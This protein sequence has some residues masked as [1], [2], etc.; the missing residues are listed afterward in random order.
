MNNNRYL[1]P[2][3]NSIKVIEKLYP[4]EPSPKKIGKIIE[5]IKLITSN[6]IYGVIGSAIET[7][8]KVCSTF[9]S[10]KQ[11]AKAVKYVVDAYE[12]KLHAEVELARLYKEKK[13]TKALTLFIE[14]SFQERMDC[15]NKE[16]LLRSREIDN[17]HSEK[18]QQI[19]S[20]HERAILKMNL[21][22]K[23]HLHTI[24]KRYA[25]MIVRN[26][27]YC[28]LYRHYLQSL[29]VQGI[30]PGI[31]IKELSHRYM[32][33]LANLASNPAISIEKIN[34][35]MDCARQL[36]ELVDNPEKYFVTFDKFID[37]KNII[38]DWSYE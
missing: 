22:A 29:Q 38:E 25:E 15:L 19:H 36:I 33:V 5:L 37:R 6:S 26:E 20:E 14:N 23:E 10:G 4:P 24:D 3:D 30:T 32:D 2:V 12:A 13:K 28:L 27:N 8:G 17:L 31:M 34:A 21:I 9:I 35:S 16:I 1:L 11:R 18:M 7:T